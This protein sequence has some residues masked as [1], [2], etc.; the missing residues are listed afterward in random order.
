MEIR[1]LGSVRLRVPGTQV[2]LASERVRSLLAALAWRADEFVSDELVIDQIWG[3]ELPR[4][5]RAALYTCATRLRRALPAGH[6]LVLRRR[7]GYLLAVDPA[8]VDLHRFRRLVAQARDAVRGRDEPVALALF[9]RALALWDDR[10]LSDLTTAWAASARVTL[11][12]ELLTAR[13]GRAELGLRLARHAEEIPFLHQLAEQHPL[14]ETIAGML[15][16]A[17]HRSGR[18]GEALASYDG[19]RRRLVDQLG[20]EPGPALRELHARI[21][22]RDADPAGVGPAGQ[23]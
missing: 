10:P 20:D 3:G 14:D 16:L 17:L 11:E 23:P 4:H 5:P 8:A 13:I 15:M 21:L 19:I 1:L 2:D 7:G 18:Q 22:R 12:R 6:S 9:D